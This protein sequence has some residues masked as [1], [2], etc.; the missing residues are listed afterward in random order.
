MARPIALPLT[1]SFRMSEADGVSVAKAQKRFQVPTAILLRRAVQIGL[2]ELRR[3]PSRFALE[4]KQDT[5]DES[6]G[7]GA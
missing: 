1:A 4:S 7:E 2:E 6:E 5:N 3:R